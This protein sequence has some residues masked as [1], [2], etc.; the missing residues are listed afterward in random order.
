MDNVSSSST[1]KLACAVVAASISRRVYM[2]QNLGVG[3]LRTHYGGRNKRKGVVPEHFNKAS[4][5]LIRHILKQLG[6][7]LLLKACAA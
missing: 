3:V 4:G 5:G 6:G 2:R 7:W 1:S